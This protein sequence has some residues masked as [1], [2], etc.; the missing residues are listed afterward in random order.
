MV[1]LAALVAL[2]ASTLAAS[3]RRAAAR[4]GRSGTRC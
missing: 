1:A 3:A 4:E 2:P